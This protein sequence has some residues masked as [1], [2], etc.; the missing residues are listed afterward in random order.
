MTD[1]ALGKPDNGG[2]PVSSDRRC[3][4]KKM[5]IRPDG[6]VPT[7]LL[8]LDGGA[9]VEPTGKHLR[10]W[11]SGW[12]LPP[13]LLPTIA[14]PASDADANWLEKSNYKLYLRKL[15]KKMKKSCVISLQRSGS[16]KM[17]VSTMFPY[18]TGHYHTIWSER[19]DIDYTQK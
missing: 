9:P 15:K 4:G 13:Q 11:R 8:L 14:R 17:A 16:G 2:V 6:R 19:M 7:K 5:P 1:R 3:A 10:C 12:S 18:N